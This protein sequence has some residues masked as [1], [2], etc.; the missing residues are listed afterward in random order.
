MMQ[1]EYRLKLGQD[2]FVLKADVKDEKQFFE[3]M[4]FYSNLPKTAPGGATDLVLVFRTTKKG[5]KY[6]SLI[7]EKEKMEFKFGQALEAT[8][9]GLFPKGWFPAYQVDADEQDQPQQQQSAPVPQ[10]AFQMPTPIAQPQVN[11]QLN[12]QF[13]G[14]VNPTTGPTAAKTPQPVPQS[15]QFF[16]LPPNQPVAQ[17][18]Q[19]P[20]AV[21]PT[22]QPAPSPQV[23]QAAN[24]VLKRFGISQPAPR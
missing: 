21:Q 3:V 10:P 23:A 14:L 16:N 4:A 24:D 19:M 12:P 15:N 6:Y 17:P 9:G 1:V 7:S 20:T 2:E 18:P 13:P 11:Q 8:G 22:T 5:H